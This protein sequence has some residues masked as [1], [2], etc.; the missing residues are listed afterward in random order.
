MDLILDTPLDM[1]LHL[2]EGAMLACV[3]PFSAGFIEA[4]RDGSAPGPRG[5]AALTLDF[6]D[7][8]GAIDVHELPAHPAGLVFH[9]FIVAH[10]L[11]YRGYGYVNATTSGEFS[12]YTSSGHP[13]RTRCGH[14]GRLGD[15]ATR[16]GRGDPE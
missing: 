6:E 11:Y 13:A 3:A 5:E 16:H 7:I 4:A 2:R 15:P 9:N 14:G 10:R 12:I 1:H 8:I